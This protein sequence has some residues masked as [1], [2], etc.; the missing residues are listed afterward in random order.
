M[1]IPISSLYG[2]LEICSLAAFAKQRFAGIDFTR[3]LQRHSVPFPWAWSSREEKQFL[4]FLKKSIR[5]RFF[6][7]SALAVFNHR[8]PK[9][10]YH[11]RKSLVNVRPASDGHFFARTA[12]PPSSVNFS[13]LRYRNIIVHPAASTKASTIRADLRRLCEKRVDG[14]AFLK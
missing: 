14:G 9:I 3:F 12:L 4:F 8:L 6:S 11:E 1:S 13:V 7:G 10:S 2:K 5:T